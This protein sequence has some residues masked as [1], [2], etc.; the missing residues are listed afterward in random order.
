MRNRFFGF[1]KQVACG[2]ALARPRFEA[3]DAAAFF[4]DPDT[5]VFVHSDMN[6]SN[7]IP[8]DV[9]GV[10]DEA[11]K[12]AFFGMVTQESVRVVG[13]Y[14]V[15]TDPSVI[16]HDPRF[17]VNLYHILVAPVTDGSQA[18][19]LAQTVKRIGLNLED[20]KDI[21]VFSVSTQFVVFK[22][23]QAEEAFCSYFP[24][25]ND[26]EYTTSFML[27]HNRFSTTFGTNEKVAHP[28]Y[29]LVH[30]G[31]IESAKAFQDYLEINRTESEATCCIVIDTTGK[32]DSGLLAYYLEVMQLYLPKKLGVPVTLGDL[33]TMT[34]AQY[35]DPS[36]VVAYAKDVL[37]LPRVEGP[38]SLAL[39]GEDGT[40]YSAK[41]SLGLRPMWFRE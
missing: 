24:L 27:S 12:A 40:M 37:G 5:V 39:M 4:S 1:L 19:P 11:K 2:P 41:D 16:Q 26:P 38:A 20:N 35:N 3:G 21:D 9:N 33:L 17:A 28:W 6:I 34:M 10:P 7:F 32:S 15:A 23:M 36:P 18:D 14:C 22:A 25:F 29:F 8:L 30:N 31:E 13:V